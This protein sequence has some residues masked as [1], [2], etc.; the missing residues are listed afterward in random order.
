MI[1]VQ[2]DLKP[3]KGSVDI[4]LSD[5]QKNVLQQKTGVQLEKG[6]TTQALTLSDEPPLG[7]WTIQVHTAEQKYSKTFDVDK[8]GTLKG[9]YC[10][11]FEKNRIRRIKGFLG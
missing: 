3:W 2:P 8:Y 5:P 7:A 4:L 6:V 11:F 10:I 9:K 1:V